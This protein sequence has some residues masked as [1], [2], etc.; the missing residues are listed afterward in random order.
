MEE[1]LSNDLWKPGAE[2][3]HPVFLMYSM[4]AVHFPEIAGFRLSK[5]RIRSMLK[6]VKELVSSWGDGIRNWNGFLDERRDTAEYSTSVNYVLAI[7]KS[8]VMK[9]KVDSESSALKTLVKEVEGFSDECDLYRRKLNKVV[10]FAK[11][12][13]DSIPFREEILKLVSIIH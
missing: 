1:S 10:D 2:P 5:D 13:D 7:M 3:M 8:K 6:R 4:A 11:K 9:K 12:N